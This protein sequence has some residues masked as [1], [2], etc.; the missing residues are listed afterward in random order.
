MADSVRA[1]TEVVRAAG[2][3]ASAAA[4]TATPGS[5]QVQPCA[6]DVVSVGASTRFAAQVTLARKY[7]AMANAMARQYGV[8]LNATAGAYDQQEAASAATLGSGGSGSA[9]A[10]LPAALTA[11]AA[12]VLPAD[13]LASG[14]GASLPAG[15]VPASPRDV[16]R[17]IETGRAGTGK[18]AWQA[19][20]S[21]LRSEARQLDDAAD[22]LRA[23]ITTTGEG[24]QSESAEAA[25][26][27]MRTLQSWYSEHARYVGGL[28]DEARAHVQNFSKALSDVPPYR[29]VLDAEREL[30]AAL[31]S[32]ARAGGAHRVAVIN[33]QMK[34][35]KLYAAS[36][37]GFSSY[38]FAESAPAPKMPTP[39]PTPSPNAA[40]IA[41][42]T[43][44][45][46]GPVQPREP[47]HS[48]TS[49]PVDP[50][51]GGHGVGQELT[52]G[53]SFP[54]GASDP[55]A[56]ADPL[57]AAM[58][59]TAGGLPAEVVPGIIG[60]VV[61]GL[62]GL[63]GGLTGAGA[64]A[65]QGIE[66]ASAQGAQ[67]LSGLGQH[68]P[69]GGEPQHGGEP[70]TPS[71]ELPSAGDLSPSGDVGAGDGGADTEP[72]GGEGP[73]AAP[74]QV[75]AAPAAAA[76]ISATSASAAPPAEAPLPAMGMAPMMPPMR[77][78]GEGGG[79]ENKQLYKD[80]K[81]KVVAP[82]NSEPVKNR[83]E[84]RTKPV[85]RKPQ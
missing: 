29:Q 81:L 76:P 1:D 30:K 44:P 36:T 67:G 84:G 24:W 34:V 2:R 38:S 20:E 37:T 8:K 74:T 45:G 75:A 51:Q 82:A 60:G 63:V 68:P 11:S 62:G 42:S 57:S 23:A 55:A 48:P 65:L 22:Q 31:Q 53:P 3:Q 59:E 50:M 18:Q 58:P 52:A 66:Q 47:Q 40:T 14:T 5:D 7:T 56:L 15:E 43:G 70:S 27:R 10:G 77:G 32:N 25:T 16:A 9:A 80:R 73:M 85:D 35:S 69:G 39:P 71:P 26:T 41:P 54:P 64:K 19:V 21:S 83:R 79:P 33:A 12:Q 49:A 6:S 28:A 13:L 78:S 61:G 4:S 46:E 72:A 17:L